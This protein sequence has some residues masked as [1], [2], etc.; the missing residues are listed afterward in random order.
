MKDNISLI[1]AAAGGF[2]LSIAATSIINAAPVNTL[3]VQ[4]SSSSIPAADLRLKPVHPDEP[5]NHT[6]EERFS[7]ENSLRATEQIKGAL[8]SFRQL[9]EKSKVALGKE[10]V[11]EVE[12]TDPETQTLGF[13]NWVGT[14]E[15]TL[16]KQ[17]YQV[18]KLEF[19]LAQEQ[20]K[21]GKINKAVLD[22]K[23]A[24]YQKTKREFQAFWNSFRIAD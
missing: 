22:Q 19:E 18:K 24:Q 12:N 16:K 11:S 23:A 3:K 13:S 17:D 21:D 4:P 10:A 5:V 1:A 6:L 8:N 15:G 7:L 14:L 9:S 20:Y 2:M